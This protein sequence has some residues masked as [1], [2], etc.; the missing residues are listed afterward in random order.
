VGGPA[1][2]WRPHPSTRGGAGGTGAR[3][4]VLPGP[5]PEPEAPPGGWAGGTGRRASGQ[6]GMY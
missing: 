4:S 2:M 6:Q 3:G 5:G 1:M